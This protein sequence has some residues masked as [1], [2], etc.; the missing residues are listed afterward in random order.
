M[1]ELQRGQLYRILYA[2]VSYVGFFIRSDDT[3]AVFGYNMCAVY[4]PIEEIAV[5]ECDVVT[6]IPYSIWEVVEHS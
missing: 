4:F 1:D 3:Y 2:G 5:V 6:L